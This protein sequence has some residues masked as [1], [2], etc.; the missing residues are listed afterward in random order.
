MQ[1]LKRTTVFLLAA[2]IFLSGLPAASVSNGSVLASAEESL[3]PDLPENE[4]MDLLEN[5]NSPPLSFPDTENS[6]D[7]VSGS[8]AGIQPSDASVIH[9]SLVNGGFEQSADSPAGWT[10]V[11]DAASGSLSIE[12]N[13]EGYVFRGARALRI[14]AVGTGDFGAISEPVRVTTGCSYLFN[15]HTR[16]E[17]GAIKATVAFHDADGNRVGE[18]SSYFAAG[19]GWKHITTNTSGISPAIAPQGAA[20]ATVSLLV[21][22]GTGGGEAYFDNVRLIELSDSLTLQNADF[23]GDIDPATGDPEGYNAWEWGY[24]YYGT[25]ELVASPVHS[26]QKSLKLTTVQRQ[27]SNQT[28]R[29]SLV[30]VAPGTEYE[31]SVYVYRERGAQ[32]YLTIEYYSAGGA[33]LSGTPAQVNSTQSNQWEKLSARAVIPADVA[34]VSLTSRQVGGVPGEYYVD[35]FDVSVVQPPVAGIDDELKNA[36]FE[37][38]AVGGLPTDWTKIGDTGAAVNVDNGDGTKSLSLTH[39]GGRNGVKSNR[40]KVEGGRFYALSV[41]NK[42]TTAVKPKLYM[43]FYA[44]DNT[45]LAAKF[46]HGYDYIEMAPDEDPQGLFRPTSAF[47]LAPENAASAE[48]AIEQDAQNGGELLVDMVDL[49]DATPAPGPAGGDFEALGTQPWGYPAGYYAHSWTSS[50]AASLQSGIV[51]SGSNAVKMDMSF[52]TQA[53]KRGGL[54]TPLVPVKPGEA[55]EFSARIYN[56]S[57]KKLSLYCYWIGAD[58]VQNLSKYPSSGKTGEWEFVTTGAVNAPSN[59]VAAAIMLYQAGGVS[60]VDDVSIKPVQLIT[61]SDKVLNPGFEE[62]L[63]EDGTVINWEKYGPNNSATISSDIVHSGN[64]AARLSASESGGNG[65]HSCKVA[66]SPNVMYRGQGMIYNDTGTSDLYLEFYNEAGNRID[67]KTAALSRTREWI[68]VNVDA[69]AP[70]DAVYAQLL[71]YQ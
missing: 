32:P 39:A 7:P 14:A 69:V 2:L 12:T 47:I 67:V 46:W 37:Q 60:Y 66:V 11:G 9:D 26:G 49:A 17:K 27:Y 54:I 15:A 40:F 3:Y 44:A 68:Q 30:S 13:T 16:T 19:T 18:E 4:N 21:T 43:R 28:I 65:L 38:G 50:A 64:Y 59:A 58:G 53:S 51:Y 41:L 42:N 63:N 24:G 1:A 22:P 70:Q 5:E 71:I 29:T 23:E 62:G 6:E 55:Y 31:F 57:D 20:Y 52:V 48:L 33:F 35:D 45:P 10:P 25:H 8:K 61:Y 36:S 34:Y 56:E